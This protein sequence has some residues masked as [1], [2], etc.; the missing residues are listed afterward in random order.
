MNNVKSKLEDNKGKTKMAI[1]TCVTKALKDYNFILKT[2]GIEKSIYTD[3]YD[4]SKL[5]M[6]QYIKELMDSIEKGKI[7]MSSSTTSSLIMTLSDLVNT[8]TQD[9]KLKDIT[10]KE[11]LIYVNDI[12][13]LNWCIQVKLIAKFNGYYTKADLTNL[14]EMKDNQYYLIKQLGKDIENDNNNGKL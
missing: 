10:L 8:I 13:T 9:T 4:Y 7:D 2:Q 12:L 1:Q 6:E 14:Q 11:I 3:E 5:L